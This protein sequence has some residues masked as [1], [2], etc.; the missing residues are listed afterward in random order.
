LAAASDPEPKAAQ[1]DDNTTI[2]KKCISL[3]IW[4]LRLSAWG[5][6]QIVGRDGCQRKFSGKQPKK[7]REISA[8][9]ARKNEFN[10]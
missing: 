10:E 6:K 7:K 4:R 5:K 1:T 3:S 2:N 9:L 8:K